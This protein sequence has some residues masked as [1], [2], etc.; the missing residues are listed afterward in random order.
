[1]KK[2]ITKIDAVTWSRVEEALAQQRELIMQ[3]L[4]AAVRA[5]P[6]AREELRARVRASVAAAVRDARMRNPGSSQAE[7]M[8]TAAAVAIFDAMN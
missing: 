3:A 7:A 2:R 1:M 5:A 4:P 8:I 6:E